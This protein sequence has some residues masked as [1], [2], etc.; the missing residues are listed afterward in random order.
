MAIAK[1]SESTAGSQGMTARARA[2]ARASC[3]T[4]REVFWKSAVWK[5]KIPQKHPV[6]PEDLFLIVYMFILF[7]EIYVKNSAIFFGHDTDLALLF[8]CKI[9]IWEE[10]H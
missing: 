8:F 4:S 6:N 9:H 1:A 3:W 7:D 5:W 10:S 2:S